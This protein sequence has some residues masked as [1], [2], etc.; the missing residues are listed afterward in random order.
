MAKVHNFNVFLGGTPGVFMGKLQSYFINS[1][2]NI[3]ASNY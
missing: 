3:S 2:Y 1:K